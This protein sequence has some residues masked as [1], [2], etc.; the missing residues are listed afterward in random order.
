MSSTLLD[1]RVIDA[2]TLTPK[3][4]AS[5]YLPIGVEGQA[6][7]AGTGV[8]GV[9]Y[10][11]NRVDEAY[12]LF[13]PASSLARLL[14]AILDRGAAPVIAVASAKGTVPTLAQRQAVWSKL[15]S[16]VNVRVRVT[17]SELQADL[18]A[19][20]VS[21]ANADL[22]Y[23]KQIGFAGLPSG[24]PKAT[25][26]SSATSIAA[27]SATGATR[28]CV[29]APGVYDDGGTLRGG[30][31]AAACVAAEVAKNSDPTN[32]LD[33]WD[34]PLLT[35]IELGA[36]GRPVFQRQVVAGVAVND[37]E[38]LLQGGIS[39]LQPSRVPGRVSTTHLRSVYVT[40]SSFDNMYTR[41]IVD[42][43]F[44]DVRDYLYDSNFLRRPNSE[45]VRGRMKAG[46]EAVLRERGEWV[47]GVTQQDNTIGYNVSVT[48]S[49]DNRQVTVGY[50]GI[51]RRGIN[52]I[53]VAASL[54]IPV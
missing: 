12:G 28:L 20:T 45:A 33:L 14:K 35:G 15:E 3:V 1:P 44:I 38:D 53:K 29:V 17:D 48:S 30:S 41:V 4:A 21:L 9:L 13:G 40:N 46:V 31:F 6:D 32:D 47:A 42:Q 16:D 8:L 2:S 39:S 23:N 52:T 36:D 50:E 26:L 27:G 43:L 37:H 19:F 34:I 49:P 24:T 18:A 22:L 7:S 10:T 11:I 51:V 5:I 54:S 25:L